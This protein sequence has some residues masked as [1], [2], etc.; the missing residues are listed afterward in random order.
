MKNGKTKS[1]MPQIGEAIFC[2]AYLVFDLIA[3]IVFFANAGGSRVLMLFGVLTLVLGGGDAFHL[4]PRVV[5]AFHGDSPKVEWWSGLGLMVS[6]IT[7][8]VFYVLLFYIWRNIF[9]AVSYP[10]I[11]PVLIWGSAALRILLCLFPQ[12]NWFRPEGNP[13]WGIYRNLP[14]AV[15]GLCLVILFFISGNIGGYGLWMMSVAIIISFACYFPVVLWAKKKPMV[16]MLMM[17]KTIAYIWMICMG[18]GLIG[19]V[20]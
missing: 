9:P 20:V 4:V 11:L 15:T 8:T 6:S 7:M 19:R 10:S 13:S 2:I 16:G 5:K 18:L 17:P 14:F 12:N 1:R 3:A